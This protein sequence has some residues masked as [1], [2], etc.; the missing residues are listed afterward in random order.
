MSTEILES[1]KEFE[2]EE[3]LNGFKNEEEN[4]KNVIESQNDVKKF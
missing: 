1:S 2:L 4:L 3:T